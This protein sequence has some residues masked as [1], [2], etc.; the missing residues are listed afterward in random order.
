MRNIKVNGE[1]IFPICIV[2]DE[3]QQSGDYRAVYPQKRAGKIWVPMRLLQ[4]WLPAAPDGG[5]NGIGQGAYRALR[6]VN[7]G[8]R[9]ADVEIG[10]R[11][12]ETSE[13]GVR[14]RVE[15]SAPAWDAGGDA[16]GVTMVELVPFVRALGG[17]IAFQDGIVHLQFR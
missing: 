3:T 17:N 15:M 6:G 13:A 16:G 1:A 7:W 11:W 9:N 8:A 5:E 14:S 2:L 4:Q 12:I 10:S